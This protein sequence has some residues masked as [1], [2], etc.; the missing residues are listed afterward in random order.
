MSSQGWD[1]SALEER[2]R[3]HVAQL[4]GCPRPP[5]T[6]AHQQAARYIQ[7]HFQLAGFQVDVQ[8][9]EEA[10][11]ECLN[12]VAGVPEQFATPLVVLGAHYDS[13]PGSPGADDN[14][15]AVAALLEIGY[16]L[17]P[18]LEAGRARLHLV[19]YDLEE[20]GL[21]G[22]YLHARALK[23]ARTHL[24]GMISLE[25]LGYCDD[26]PGSQRMPA[27]L[28][29]RYPEVGNFIGIVGN[30]DSRGLLETVV[31]G[32]KQAGGV[33]VESIAVPDRGETLAETRFSDHS[34]FWDHDYPALMITDTSFF[35]NPHYHRSS[36][37]PDKLDY[38]FL[39]RVTRAVSNAVKGLLQH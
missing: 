12:V 36:D 3:G 4:A 13:V 33:P 17:R 5:G 20:Y 9:F 10:G 37:T 6:E 35:R 18:T 39:A 30:E 16:Q 21:I 1:L 19:A 11:L 26:R 34:S 14:A 38:G 27:H 23:Q 24:L 25:M 7:Q 29:P 32:M 22:S 2:L 31:T 8:C 28:A 15:S